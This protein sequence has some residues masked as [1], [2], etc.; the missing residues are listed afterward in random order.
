MKA[1][2]TG[3]AGF[4]GSTLVD[5][6]LEMGWTVTGIDSFTP[7]YP[8]QTKLANLSSASSHDRFELVEADLCVHDLDALV[9]GHDFVFHQAG[10]PGVRASWADGFDAYVDSNIRATQR[11]LEAS[12][13]VTGLRFIYASSSSVYGATTD[14]PTT[15]ST[16][17]SPRSPYGV[18]KLAGE[19]LVSLYAANYGLE[20]ASLRYFTVYGPRQR[21][22]MATHRLLQFALQNQR[23]HLFG[24][25]E[26]VRDFTHVGDVVEA[27]ILAA[28]AD[29]R[30]GQTMNIA[31][32]SS[33]SM[34]ELISAAETATGCAIDVIR[35]DVALGDVPR[36]E[37]ST[38]LARSLLG[39]TPRVSLSE[40]LEQ[41]TQAIRHS[42]TQS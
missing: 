9:A 12:A 34:I 19:H 30:S 17:P 36:T 33:T 32:G 38:D 42:L 10:Q 6:C 40:G 13:R 27:N 35:D 15:E 21:P 26:A 2:V 23:F 29:I 39:W 24:T 11:L 5:R 18:T 41:Q 3:A 20:T 7:H 16:L 14:F 37:A 25:G 22:D 4:I 31:G 28:T 1:V 8:R